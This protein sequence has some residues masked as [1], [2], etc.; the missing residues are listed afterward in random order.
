LANNSGELDGVAK[1]PAKQRIKK[2]SALKAGAPKKTA[3]KP[4][5]P[6][7]ALAQSAPSASNFALG[8]LVSHPMFGDGTVTA[9]DADKLTIEF[10][11]NVVK[12]ILDYY[13]KPRRP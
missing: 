9:I 13:V 12:Q 1:K 11:G 6:E 4:K 2:A 3:S 7:P 8:H 10:Q 5:A